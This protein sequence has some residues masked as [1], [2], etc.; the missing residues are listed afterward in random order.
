MTLKV[1]VIKPEYSR[2]YH[3]D[4]RKI[5]VRES[6]PQEMGEV[7]RT[8]ISGSDQVFQT[9]VDD[10]GPLDMVVITKERIEEK[11]ITIEPNRLDW[12][13]IYVHSAFGNA[14]HLYKLRCSSAISAREAGK[15]LFQMDEGEDVPDYCIE[16]YLAGKEMP[17]EL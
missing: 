9:V 11:E 15:T 12:Y 5:L 8:T 2:T 7:Q 17:K 14:S 10:M 3:G 6:V 13:L 1:T 16:V 4:F